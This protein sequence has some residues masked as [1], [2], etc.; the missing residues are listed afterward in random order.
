M[1]PVRGFDRAAPYKGALWRVIEGQSRSS[2][3]RLVETFAEHDILE[4]MLEAAKPAVPQECQHLDY[5]FWSPFRYGCYPKD[6][7]FRRAGR[8]PGVWYGSEAPITAMCETIWGN[9]RFFG[10]SKSTP[11][12]RR[13]VEYT[14]VCADIGAVLALDL[15]A[16]DW[17][18]QGRWT[19]PTDYTDCLTLADDFRAAGGGALRYT[20]VRA[21]DHAANVAVLTCHAFATAYPTLHQTWR[22]LYGPSVQRVTN[23][24]DGT[25]HSLSVGDASFLFIS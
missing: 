13:P 19:D 6:S 15:T 14:A 9:L 18:G 23:D 11:L 10:A 4:A 12:P 24:S 1:P 7:R 22:V 3:L 20:S 8:T 2:T 21:P 17:V 5:Q 25:R 16:P